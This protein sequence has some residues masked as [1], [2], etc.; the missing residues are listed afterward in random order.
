MA[1]KWVQKHIGD[2]IHLLHAKNVEMI[3]KSVWIFGGIQGCFNDTS[4]SNC[5]GCQ[6]KINRNNPLPFELF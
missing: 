2:Y 3:W 5:Q 4:C 6:C 1:E